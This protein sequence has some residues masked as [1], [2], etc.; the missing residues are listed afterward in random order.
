LGARGL[1]ANSRNGEGQN[2]TGDTTIF[3]RVLY[4]PSYLAW[5]RVDG[6]YR[7]TRGDTFVLTGKVL[8]VNIQ[9][10]SGLTFAI[11]GPWKKG[12]L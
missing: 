9:A 3:S 1:R 4:Q 11:W 6:I 8:F 5:W 7:F 12:A 2:R 10:R